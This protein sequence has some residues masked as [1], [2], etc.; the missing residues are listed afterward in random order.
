[1]DAG[2]LTAV[3]KQARVEAV[4]NK[5][6][7]DEALEA[8]EAIPGSGVMIAAIY[9]AGELIG[10]NPDQLEMAAKSR[11]LHALIDVKSSGVSGTQKEG[12]IAGIGG[13]TLDM[14]EEIMGE[15]WSSTRGM[16]WELQALLGYIEKYF[17]GDAL[18]AVRF[19]KEAEEWG[20]SGTISGGSDVITQP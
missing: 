3:V 6:A 8:D 14:Y 16:A 10:M 18:A 13:L 1:M 20:G 2:E 4:A 12:T 5:E 17:Q 9:Q 15:E 11:A 19:Y 7:W